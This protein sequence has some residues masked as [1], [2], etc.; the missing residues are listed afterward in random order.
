[1]ITHVA[2]QVLTQVPDFGGGVAPPGSEKLLTMGRWVLWVATAI[3]VIAFIIIGAR[4]GISHRHGEMEQHGQR[5]GAAMAGCV[6]IGAATG[7][8]GALVG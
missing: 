1:M 6:V 2:L 5:L 4:M 3:C 8:A 7:I